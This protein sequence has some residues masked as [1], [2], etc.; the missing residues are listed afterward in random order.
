VSGTVQQE[1]GNRKLARQIALLGAQGNARHRSCRKEQIKLIPYVLTRDYRQQERRCGLYNK[2]FACQI[3]TRLHLFLTAH[4]LA[5]V[6]QGAPQSCHCSFLTCSP[7]ANASLVMFP[8]RLR[9]LDAIPW[10]TNW[11]PFTALA[12]NKVSSH[13]PM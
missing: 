7:A 8:R 10:W 2:K 12:S 5:E 9:S 1:V 13:G 11:A 4:S 6:A 3:A